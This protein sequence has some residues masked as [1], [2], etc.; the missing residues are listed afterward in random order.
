MQTP[1]NHFKKS[2]LARQAQIGLWLGLSNPLSAEICAW[3]GFD[4]LLIDGEHAPN[5]LPQ[6]LAQA[7]TIAGVPGN[8]VLA[9][10]PVGDPVLVKQYLDLGVQ[11]LLIPMVESAAQAQAMVQAARYPQADGQGGMRGMAGARASR[12]GHIAN[13]AQEANGQVCV[14]VQV[15]TALGLENLQ[16]ICDTPGIDGVFIGPADLSASLGFPGQTEHPEVL[17]RIEKAIEAI[18]RAG[19]APGILTTNESLARR[20]LELG[21]LFICVGLD[22]NLLMQHT[23]ALAARFKGAATPSTP[24]GMGY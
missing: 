10:L 11:T 3:A 21:V 8:Q 23:R 2:L 13:Y 16:E 6:I 5:T 4:W 19:K 20:Y 14:L 9:R 17:A 7:Q 22:T 15:E 24:S 12:W 1:T 18:S